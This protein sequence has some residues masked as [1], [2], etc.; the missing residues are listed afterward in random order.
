M[1]S[2]VSTARLTSWSSIGVWP[3]TFLR[4]QLVP[5][6]ALRATHGEPQWPFGRKMRPS[7]SAARC[8]VNPP[9]KLPAL[10]SDPRKAGLPV[11]TNGVVGSPPLL[12]RV[13]D[14]SVTR[15]KQ[16]YSMFG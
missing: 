4:V 13:Q 15:L 9:Q 7:L 10:G 5:A 12:W 16:K 3:V 6:S 1:L 11:S 2:A 14:E 8:P